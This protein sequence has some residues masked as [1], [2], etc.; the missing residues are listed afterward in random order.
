[1]QIR[2]GQAIAAAVACALVAVVLPAA[3]RSA[4][5]SAIVASKFPT[6]KPSTISGC[7][8]K[9]RKRAACPLRG[10]GPP[11]RD[12]CLEINRLIAGGLVCWA[13]SGVVSAEFVQPIHFTVQ[14]AVSPDHLK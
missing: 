12:C 13:V 4:F 9:N 11:H 14:I 5:N 2:P 1:M 8:P 3:T 10:F 7:I 6:S